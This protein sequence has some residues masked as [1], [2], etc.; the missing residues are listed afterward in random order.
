MPKNIPLDDLENFWRA[1]FNA[2]SA[3]SAFGVI[4]H[5]N[6]GFKTD[7]LLGAV[8]D[9]EAAFDAG[10]LAGFNHH[11]FN[12]VFVGTQGKRTRPRFGNV[13]YQALG[14]FGHAGTAAGAFGVVYHGQALFS[15]KRHCAEFADLYAV[16]KTKAAP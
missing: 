14:T 13:L 10:D 3:G 7:A 4:H 9:A 12:G 6:M 8:L 1:F 5:R 11:L 16:A 15:V 2:G